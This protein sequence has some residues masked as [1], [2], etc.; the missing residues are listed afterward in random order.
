[1]KSPKPEDTHCT[2]PDYTPQFEYMREFTEV[3]LLAIGRVAT[4]WSH[5][6]QTLAMGLWRVAGVDNKTGICFTAQIPNSARMFDAL[7]ALCHLRGASEPLLK[8]IKKVAEKTLGLQEQR[9]RVLHDVWT[10]DPGL[11]S[12]WPLTARRVV[13]D[14]SVQVTTE[15]VER[16]ADAIDRHERT[17]IRLLHY[18]YSELGHPGYDSE[19]AKLDS[20]QA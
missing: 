3:H 9:N 2:L 1:M 4:R 19:V 13:S 12:R 5:L 20:P 7:L 8:K 18:V 17:L 16:F 10:F 14:E 6:E 15:E 11:I